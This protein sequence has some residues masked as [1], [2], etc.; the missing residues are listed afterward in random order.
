[1]SLRLVLAVVPVAAALAVANTGAASGTESGPLAGETPPAR[2]VAKSLFRT[3]G[4]SAF[5]G[6]KNKGRSSPLLCWS[7]KTGYTVTLSP[8]GGIPAGKLVPANRAL[9]P[10][11][12]AFPLL[13]N[14]KSLVHGSYRCSVTKGNARCTNQARHGF[15]VGGA[16]TF[17]F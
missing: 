13:R 16:A 14:G 7:P 2:L 15:V 12:A 9:P 4:N 11:P 1:M 10:Q 3:K 5:C 8:N 17:R 6:L